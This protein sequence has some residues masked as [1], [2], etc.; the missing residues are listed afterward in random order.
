M[1]RESEINIGNVAC[2]LCVSM[3]KNVR[4]KKINYDST[5]DTVL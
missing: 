2:V 1:Y 5:H 3:Y 4:E